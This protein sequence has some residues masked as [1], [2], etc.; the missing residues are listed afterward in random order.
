MGATT[1]L[2][3]KGGLIDVGGT[4]ETLTDAAAK[5]TAALSSEVSLI[6]SN[7]TI[8]TGTVR[9]PF[10]RLV[11]CASRELSLFFFFK[12]LALSLALS[13]SLSL[14]PPP[15]YTRMYGQRPPCQ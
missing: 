5:V 2:F 3:V 1:V 9:R 6:I 11:I 14:S 8:T 13:L 4:V 10:V 15:A 12:C 7:F